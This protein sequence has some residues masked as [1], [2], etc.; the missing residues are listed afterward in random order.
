M[1]QPQLILSCLILVILDC[2]YS[3]I[4]MKVKKYPATNQRWKI[5]VWITAAIIITVLTLL[6]SYHESFTYWKAILFWPSLICSY[7]ILKNGILGL[8]WHGNFFYLGSKGFDGW[9]QIYTQN[10]VL[11]AITYAII[12]LVG[13]GLWGYVKETEKLKNK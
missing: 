5:P 1:T 4:I 9:V 3:I 10:G 8:Y 11:T 6:T 2:L 12:A 7:M 13:Y